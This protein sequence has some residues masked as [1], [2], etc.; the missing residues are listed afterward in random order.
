[1]I[2]S[3]LYRRQLLDERSMTAF[4]FTMAGIY[5]QIREQEAGIEIIDCTQSI[6]AT[7][8]T[9]TSGTN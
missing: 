8:S 9:C 2:Q 7:T 6:V 4:T 3:A 1:M 5:K